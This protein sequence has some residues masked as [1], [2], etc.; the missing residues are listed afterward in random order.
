MNDFDLLKKLS[1]EYPKQQIFSRKEFVLLHNLLKDYMPEFKDEHTRNSILILCA[2]GLFDEINI[3]PAQKLRAIPYILN[4]FSHKFLRNYRIFR[5][6][7]EKSKFLNASDD[8]AIKSISDMADFFNSQDAIDIVLQTISP[9]NFEP[10]NSTAKFL[11]K[12]IE[13]NEPEI[14][15]WYNFSKLQN[16]LTIPRTKKS[17]KNK[18]LALCAGDFF[19][20]FYNLSK[21]NTGINEAD[22]A[23]KLE[24]KFKKTSEALKNQDS[25]AIQLV[26]F[27]IKEERKKR[28]IFAKEKAALIKNKALLLKSQALKRKKIIVASLAAFVALQVL[29]VFLEKKAKT[30]AEFF[31]NI[32][33]TNLDNIKID[34]RI[35]T[36]LNPRKKMEI[37]Y[38]SEPSKQAERINF[39]QNRLIEE[40][41]K[42][43]AEA[44][45]NKK[46]KELYL[47]KSLAKSKI[48]HLGCSETT[49]FQTGKFNIKKEYE[50][51]KK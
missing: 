41:K 18:I 32:A 37:R 2:V 48:E 12:I 13:K 39:V 15:F 38:F 17:D 47:E 11:N 1:G 50:N 23:S 40:T 10:H 9:Q 46:Q 19:A 26:N 43:R 16:I 20:Y 27:L 8:A 44:L 35:N 29:S 22:F 33:W 49:G 36:H 7:P 51:L 6:K 45:F 3:K 24:K 30:H 21:N 28:I 14:L 25:L 42:T 4:R 31:P 5:S 34:N